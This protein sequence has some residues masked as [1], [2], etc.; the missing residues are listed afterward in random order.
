MKNKN[1]TKTQK[2][3]RI[4]ITSFIKMNK[5]EAKIAKQQILQCIIEMYCIDMKWQ[6]AAI[7]DGS[8]VLL[9]PQLSYILVYIYMIIIW[10]IRL[11]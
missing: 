3:D 10:K 9:C 8:I 6:C 4:N 11:E 7:V 1:K 5:R 2:T